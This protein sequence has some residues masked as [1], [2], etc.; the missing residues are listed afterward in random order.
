MSI[1]FDIAQTGFAIRP[2]EGGDA[3]AIRM[4]LP[5]V[6]EDGDRF[7]AVDASHGLV[8]GA[9]VATRA[10]RRKDRPGPGVA[11]HV[12]EPC[13]RCGVGRTLLDELLGRAKRCGARALYGVHRIE[14][15]GLAIHAW[16]WMGFAVCETSEEHDLPIAN[17]EARLAPLVER[18]MGTGKV[19][20]GAEVVPLHAA[21]PAAV[22]RLHI[23]NLGGDPETLLRRVRGQ[24]PGSFHPR[25]SLALMLGGVVVGCLLGHRQSLRAFVVDAVVVDPL[26]RNGWANL[27]LKREAARRVRPEGAT[28]IQFTSFDHYSDTRRFTE[29][30]GGVTTRRRALMRRSI[31]EG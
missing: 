26:L 24:A 14:M 25:Y 4:L 12:V 21:D 11:I 20:A 5:E 30:L 17:V 6:P 2:A 9:A 13:R 10:W 27:L 3:K 16:Q 31:R 1:V 8:I 19:P 18:M 15:D 28:H 23:A 7:V 22:V 29:K